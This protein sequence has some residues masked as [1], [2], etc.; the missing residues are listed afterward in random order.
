MLEDMAQVG[1]ESIVSWQPHGEAFR[2]HL[3]EVFARTVMPRYF[4]KQT[5]YKSFLRQLHLYGFQRIGKGM[6]R[7]AYFHSMFI[8][9]EK[10]MSLR[11]A[12][13][14]VKR[15][16]S[17]AAGNQ[18]DF[19]SLLKTIDMGNDQFQDR[20]SSV[21]SGLQSDPRRMLQACITSTE[22]KQKGFYLNDPATVFT[23]NVS[24]DHQL[25]DKEEKP[26]LL[27]RSFLFHQQE[28][29]DTAV[30]F[31]ASHQ[32]CD[33]KDIID[34]AVDWLELLGEDEFNRDDDEG[35]FFGNRFFSVAETENTSWKT[36][37]R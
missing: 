26:S 20:S 33:K 15:K 18:P 2:V 17:S 36:S 35:I 4:L 34:A 19:Y 8:R 7:G 16:N 3:P 29:A 25:L 22:E 23:T 32:R 37:A 21:T 14:K 31:P 11:M 28:E 10:S 13:Q 24:I 12:R 6:D 27:M 5:K 1:D 9:N 30:P